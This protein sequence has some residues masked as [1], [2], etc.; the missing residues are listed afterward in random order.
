MLSTDVEVMWKATTMKIK[1]NRTNIERLAVTG[2]R[3]IVTDTEI[4][5][6]RIVVSAKGKKA[7]YLRYRVGGGRAGTIREPKIGDFGLV[8]PEQARKIALDWSSEV[9]SGGD[10]SNERQQRRAAPNMGMLFDRYLLEHATVHKKPSSVRNDRSIIKGHLTPVFGSLKVTEVAREDVI[11]F[12][13]S[14]SDR[15]YQANR[16]LA[17]LSKAFSLAEYWGWRS[18]RTNPTLHVRKYPEEKRRRYLSTEESFRLSETLKRADKDGFLMVPDQ[19]GE[20]RRKPVLPQAVAVIRLLL[21]TGARA[22]EIISMRWE[23]LDIPNRE[24]GLPESKIGFR[25][26]HLN[27][28]AVDVLNDIIAVPGNPYVITGN[29]EGSHL[30]NIKDPWKVIRDDAGL[31]NF[32]LHD[33]RHSFASYAVSSGMSLPIVGALLGHSQPSTTA[34]YAH[35]ASDPLK[36]AVQKIGDEI[37]TNSEK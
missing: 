22:M 20:L 28:A 25:I 21:F 10:P 16:A 29:K 31:L 3:Y 27:D 37:K 32:R 14:L 1:L 12:H 2:S 6:F 11:R 23:W 17:L 30:V 13:R 36:A 33:L 5:G 34:R 4:P 26:I 35:L 9:R 7:F 15:P 18:D 24:L 19:D 8:T